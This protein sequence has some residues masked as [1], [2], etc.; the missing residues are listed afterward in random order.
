MACS[1]A[2][3]SSTSLYRVKLDFSR[4]DAEPGYSYLWIRQAKPYSGDTYGWH[5][6]L[7]DGTEVGI[8]YDGGD[9]DRPY[10]AHAFTGSL[11]II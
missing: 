6:P 8:A 10:I 7:M 9:I 4:E 5:T 2:V 3:N 1:A 11:H